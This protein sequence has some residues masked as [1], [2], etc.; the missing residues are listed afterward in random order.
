MSVEPDG[1]ES[2]AVVGAGQLEPG[3]DVV[4]ALTGCDVSLTEIDES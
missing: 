1:I 2:V 4:A 3:I